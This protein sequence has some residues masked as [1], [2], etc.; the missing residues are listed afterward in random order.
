MDLT[1]I[2]ASQTLSGHA[3]TSGSFIGGQ[4]PQQ[5]VN[6]GIGGNYSQT[7]TFSY[8]PLQGKD[9]FKSFFTP[10]P[11]NV[12]IG[13][14]EAGWGVDRV[15]DITVERSNNL[16]NAPNASGPT[17]A[18]APR[19]QGFAK[20]TQL[21]GHQENQGKVR[22]GMDRQENDIIFNFF[23]LEE[24]PNNATRNK[25]I[26]KLLELK[27]GLPHYEINDKSLQ[28]GENTISTHTRSILGVM[29][30]LSHGIDVPQKD[31]DNGLVTIT[32]NPDGT[33]F[34]WDLLSGR[35]LKVYNSA[36]Y[37]E[38]V[39]VA[40]NYR[41]TWFYIK[42]NDLNS[43][44]TFLLA[45]QLFNLRQVNQISPTLTIPVSAPSR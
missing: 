6:A 35:L 4:N 7:P 16:Q 41:D 39:F 18:L 38:N 20:L 44:T 42:D 33:V 1:S 10:I 30:F 9:F 32:K 25:E 14:I 36:S 43:K 40:I 19:Y 28:L 45:L 34:N 31:I 11:L 37:P 23:K 13:L 24:S 8:V 26:L 27:P 21:L 17:P 15:L 29:F 3:S 5:L 22:I 2:T 12:V